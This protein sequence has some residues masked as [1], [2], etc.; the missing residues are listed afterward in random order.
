MTMENRFDPGEIEVQRDSPFKHDRL[1]RQQFVES[2][3]EALVERPGGVVALDG[4][5]GAGKTTVLRMIEAVLRGREDA[6]VV[7]L[8]AWDND[9]LSDAPTALVADL[10]KAIANEFSLE[11]NSVERYM[12]KALRVAEPLAPLAGATPVVGK[13]AGGD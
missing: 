3:C 13:L 12:E 2:L 4:G 7:L 10:F 8:N 1:K 9:H 6:R 11:P 5:W